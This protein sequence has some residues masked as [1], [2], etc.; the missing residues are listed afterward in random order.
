MANLAS[1]HC[2][3]LKKGTKP[4]SDSVARSLLSQL[5]S[6]WQ[7]NKTSIVREFKFRDYHQTISFVNAVAWI[8]NQQDHHPDLDVSYKTCKVS[9]TSHA[10]SGLTVNDFICAAR[11][12]AITMDPTSTSTNAT[13]RAE[14]QKA[15]TKK[16]KPA[17]KTAAKSKTENE[18]EFDAK[19]AD[20]LLSPENLP[21]APRKAHIEDE[22]DEFELIDVAGHSLTETNKAADAGKPEDATVKEKPPL[23]SASEKPKEK[24]EM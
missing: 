3:A 20:A 15:P 8:A 16:A 13:A 18:F 17:D 1:R 10:A 4:I 19:E 2:T 24:G 23:P 11:I 7:I 22:E 6:A 14:R 9:Y 5:N 12:D 21:K